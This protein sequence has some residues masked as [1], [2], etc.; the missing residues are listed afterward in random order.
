[1]VRNEGTEPVSFSLALEIGCDFADI[2]SVKEH[3]FALGDPLNAPPLPEPVEPRYDEE[4]NQFVLVDPEGEARTQVLLS[5]RGTLNGSGIEYEELRVPQRRSK[6]YEIEDLTG[7]R[8]VPVLV[9]GEEVVYDS[10]RILE[11]LSSRDDS[12]AP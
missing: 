8:W 11:Y 9:D 7:Q 12:R 10:H 4:N 6:R 1:M 2:M 5:Q 3:D